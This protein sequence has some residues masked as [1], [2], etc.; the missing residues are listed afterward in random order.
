M[1]GTL[2]ALAALGTVRTLG[3]RRGVLVAT[4]G[5]RVRRAV[6]AIVAP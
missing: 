1:A 6:T 4:A 2:A 3:T 5:T